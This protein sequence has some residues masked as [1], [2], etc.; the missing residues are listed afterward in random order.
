MNNNRFYNWDKF[1][2]IKT[3]IS[4]GSSISI[5]GLMDT[6][7]HHMVYSVI[8]KTNRKVIYIA[9]N[10]LQARNAF[11]NFNGMSKGRVLYFPSEKKCSTM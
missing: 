6:Q 5:N 10:E 4:E 11:A 9:A 2:E 8:A 3:D 1:C 7:R